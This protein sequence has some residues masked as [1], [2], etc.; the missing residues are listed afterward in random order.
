[1]I[2]LAA[3]AAASSAVAFLVV[4][5]AVP[6]LARLL[7]ARGHAVRDVCKRGRVMV[8]RPGGPA[9]VAGIVA[10]EL[11]LYAFVQR[12]EILAVILTTAGAFAAGYVD[13]RR[14]MGGWFKPAALCLAAA[15]IIVLGTYDTDLAFPLFGEVHIPVLYLALIVIMICITGNTVNSIDVA[16]GAASGFMVISGLA[17]AACMMIMGNYEMAAAALPLA[18]AALAFYRY[19]RIPS[20]IF[21]GDS[22]A[23]A[24]GAMYGA[25]A[26]VGEA[27]VVAAV[28]LLPAI[29]NSFLFLASMKRI[30]EHR[31]I[32]RPVKITDDMRLRATDERDAPV[33]LVRLIVSGGPLTEGQVVRTILGL[34][35]MMGAMAV[36]T[37]FLM[38]VRL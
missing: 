23:L 27:E 25:L 29:I 28:A 15:P 1:M 32:K 21:P 9:I 6:P 37:A 5:A 18:F 11:V 36:G 10:S 31:Q 12:T 24:F 16:N 30:V 20:S 22:G 35:A 33:T 13:D 34:A 8:A 17:L 26:I 2:G 7:R 3:A 38:G 4:L 14:V 19:H